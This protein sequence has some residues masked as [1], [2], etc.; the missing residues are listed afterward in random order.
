MYWHTK[1]TREIITESNKF[2]YFAE[3]GKLQVC[4][5]DWVDDNGATRPGKTVTIDLK[6]GTAELGNLFFEIGACLAVDKEGT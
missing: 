5:P 1:P 4:R 3:D 2:R 6:A